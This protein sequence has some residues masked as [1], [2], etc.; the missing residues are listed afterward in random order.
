MAR[1]GLISIIYSHTTELHG[2][3][4]KDTSAL[5]LMGTDVERIVESLKS[6]HETW[7]SI[8]EVAVALFLLERQ[9]FLACL[10]PACICFGG[11]SY[12]Y[13]DIFIWLPPMGLTWS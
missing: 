2:S 3:D 11:Y 12:S 9:I 8:I 1:A 7:A 13:L 10:V 6:L 5:T 4:V